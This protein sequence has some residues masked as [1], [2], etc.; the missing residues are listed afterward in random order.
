MSNDLFDA[1]TVLIDKNNSILSNS[2][3][4]NNYEND[5]DDYALFARLF[6]NDDDEDDFDDVENFSKQDIKKEIELFIYIINGDKIKS[7]TAIFWNEQK[8]SY[9]ICF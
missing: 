9:L 1:T 3:I 2:N 7:S 6:A 4:N 8:K 5:D